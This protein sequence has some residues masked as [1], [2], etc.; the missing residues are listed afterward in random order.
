MRGFRHGYYGTRLYRIYY[1][2][3]SRCYTESVPCSQY[4][5]GK[6]V[7]VCKE[8]LDSFDSFRTWALSNGYSEQLTL[9]RINVHGDYS[10][11]NCRWIPMEAQAKNKSRTISVVIDVVKYSYTNYQMKLVYLI[12]RCTGDI[13][14]KKIY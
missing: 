2:M 3:K 9:D 6:G 12:V 8:W 1:N 4:Y 11:S 10:P 13:K 5:G 14:T 7:G